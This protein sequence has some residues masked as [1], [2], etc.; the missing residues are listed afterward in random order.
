MTPL[1]ALFEQAYSADEVLSRYVYVFYVAFIVSFIFTPIMRRV[2]TYY[3]IIDE[4]DALRKIHSQPVAYLGGIA[5]FLGWLS[6]LAFSQFLSLH[7]AEPGLLPHPQVKF[8][9]VVGATAIVLLGLYDD[10]FRLSP[11]MKIAGQLFAAVCLLLEGVGTRCLNPIL[12]PI[13]L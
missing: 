9:I 11:K 4:P 3:G 7:R 5:V 1:L 6:A 8:S 10:I 13:G 12:Q 2:A